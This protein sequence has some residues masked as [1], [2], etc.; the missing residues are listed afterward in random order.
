[1]SRRGNFHMDGGPV[2]TVASLIL[3][4]LIIQVQAFDTNDMTQAYT[5]EVVRTQ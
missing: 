4:G 1:M 5:L 3:E 2:R